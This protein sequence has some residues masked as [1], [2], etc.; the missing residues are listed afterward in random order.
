MICTTL[1]LCLL[2]LGY[3]SISLSKYEA[4]YRDLKVGSHF[5]ELEPATIELLHKSK[6]VDVTFPRAPNTDN[7]FIFNDKCQPDSVHHIFVLPIPEHPGF[8]FTIVFSYNYRIIRINNLY[9]HA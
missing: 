4:Q 6:E 9:T 8:N 5:S 7:C 1:I 3:D 2:N